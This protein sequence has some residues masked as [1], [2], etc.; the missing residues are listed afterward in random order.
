M[1]N[2]STIDNLLFQLLQIEVAHDR[3]LGVREADF[4][5]LNARLFLDP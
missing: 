4:Y 5:P 2:K 1:R 3:R